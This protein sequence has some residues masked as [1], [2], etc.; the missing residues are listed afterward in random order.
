MPIELTNTSRAAKANPGT[1]P[2]EG[3]PL[4]PFFAAN[5]VIATGAGTP[6][7]ARAFKADGSTVVADFSVGAGKTDIKLNEVSTTPNY[8]IRITAF[9]FDSR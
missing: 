4:L 3:E 7:F 6:G 9:E 8:P 1:S 2:T 5:P